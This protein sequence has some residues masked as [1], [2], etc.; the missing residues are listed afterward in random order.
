MQFACVSWFIRYLLCVPQLRQSRGPPHP[1][2]VMTTW[3]HRTLIT[4]VQ[5][6]HVTDAHAFSTDR[7]RRS[8]RSV[9]CS[10]T[11]VLEY[12]RYKDG[13]QVTCACAVRVS[14]CISAEMSL[15][16]LCRS[17]ARSWYIFSGQVSTCIESSWRICHVVSLRGAIWPTGGMNKKSR[18]RGER[19]ERK[20]SLMA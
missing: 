2:R 6:H 17:V 13:C 16:F 19:R 10:S 18:N 12:T 11:M 1:G 5:R 15:H 4:R 20:S 7:T 3:P 14:E 9:W 8:V